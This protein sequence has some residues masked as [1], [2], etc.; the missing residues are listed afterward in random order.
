MAVSV[1]GKP[2][3]TGKPGSYVTLDRAWAEGDVASF[4]LPVALACITLYGSRSNPRP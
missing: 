3:A 1:N 2:A 4:T